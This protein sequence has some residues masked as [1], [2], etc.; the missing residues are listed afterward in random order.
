[1]QGQNCRTKVVR[2][3]LTD[4]QSYLPLAYILDT[5]YVTSSIISIYFCISFQL[6]LPFCQPAVLLPCSPIRSALKSYLYEKCK[7]GE[8]LLQVSQW[9]CEKTAVVA[10]LPKHRQMAMKAPAILGYRSSIKPNA[11]GFVLLIFHQDL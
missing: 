1:M 5:S 8:F 7:L 4:Q 11:A 10:I 9:V 3:L 2:G 6:G